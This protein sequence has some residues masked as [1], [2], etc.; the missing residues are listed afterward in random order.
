[1]QC[2]TVCNKYVDI[3]SVVQQKMHVHT[4]GALR[5]CLAYSRIKPGLSARSAS[6]WDLHQRPFLS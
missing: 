5:P 3:C 6:S 2:Y 1:M 4:G